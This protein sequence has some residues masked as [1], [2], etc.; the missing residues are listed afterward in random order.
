MK[1]EIKTTPFHRKL[2]GVA[3][4]R[5]GEQSFGEA[6]RQLL[7]K[8]W[9]AI[10]PLDAECLD[11]IHCVYDSPHDLFVGVEI[12]REGMDAPEGVE[13]RYIN[14]HRRLEYNHDGPQE[15][16]PD[17]LKKLITELELHGETRLGPDV[18]IYGSQPDDSGQRGATLMIG[19][20]DPNDKLARK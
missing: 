6:G 2:I 5:S 9:P 13:Y 4:K 8:L 16:L 7:D 1:F 11:V 15:E 14:F 19:L 3:G 20:L 10:R 17:V 12:K 18:A